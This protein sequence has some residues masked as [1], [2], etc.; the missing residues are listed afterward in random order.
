MFRFENLNERT[1]EFMLIELEFDLGREELYLSARLKSGSEEKYYQLLRNA[2]DNGT[3]ES[4]AENILNRD[5]LNYFEV[6]V[7][8][9]GKV[10]QAKVPRY[11]HFILAEGEFNRYYIR[12]LCLRAKEDGIESLEIYRAKDVRSPRSSSTMLIGTY[13][14]PQSLL[15]DLRRNLGVDISLGVPQG[16]NSGLSVRIK[17]RK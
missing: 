11:A 8:K 4:F 16:P 6:R 17:A 2:L 5:L 7:S 1:R 12:S 14:N 10:I 15:E 9:T 13:I 3:P